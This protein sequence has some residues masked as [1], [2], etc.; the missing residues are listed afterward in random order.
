MTLRGPA[1]A[2]S[3]ACSTRS[4]VHSHEFSEPGRK[5]GQIRQ[6]HVGAGGAEIVGGDRAGGYADGDGIG[7]LGGSY[8]AEVVAD[9]DGRAVRQQ[10]LALLFGEHVSH[11]DIR[12]EVEVIEVQLRQPLQLRGDHEDLAVAATYRL[13]RIES[14]RQ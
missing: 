13:E 5:A 4:V 2:W 7:C 11:Q 1:P 14:A 9:V 6:H 10:H 12:Y 3:G 8:V